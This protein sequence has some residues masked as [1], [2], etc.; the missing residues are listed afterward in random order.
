MLA[1]S[2]VKVNSP[3]RGVNAQRLGTTMPVLETSFC[4]DRRPVA[5]GGELQG[6]GKEGFRRYVKERTG[7]HIGAILA[8]THREYNFVLVN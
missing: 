2:R 3:R 4:T 7:S 8:R 6:A 5:H 1:F